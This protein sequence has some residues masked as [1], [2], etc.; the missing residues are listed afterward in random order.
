VAEAPSF[1]WHEKP[2]A[3]ASG[4][5]EAKA[6]ADRPADDGK[7][8]NGISAIRLCS[9]QSS[10]GMTARTAKAKAGPPP[11]AKD[12]KSKGDDDKQGRRFGEFG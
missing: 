12:D 10:S 2:Q 6:T 8:C 5:L 7:K 3:E 1:G 9:G 11:A 4:Y